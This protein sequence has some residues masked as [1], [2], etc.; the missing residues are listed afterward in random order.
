MVPDPL[1]LHSRH[2]RPAQ[3]QAPRGGEGLPLRPS[4]PVGAEGIFHPLPGKQEEV[5]AL[6]CL[7]S[8]LDRPSPPGPPGPMLRTPLWTDEHLCPWGHTAVSGLRLLWLW[9]YLRPCCAASSRGLSLGYPSTRP[10][11][12]RG[13]IQLSFPQVPAVQARTGDVAAARSVQ[14]SAGKDSAPRSL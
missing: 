12:P 9:S 4:Y 8:C 3:A 11:V 10:H 14:D 5:P 13:S 7:V 2:P 1:H 6:W